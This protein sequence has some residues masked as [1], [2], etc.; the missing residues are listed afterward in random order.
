MLK[1]VGVLVFLSAQI[2]PGEQVFLVHFENSEA[3]G[4]QGIHYVGGG[5]EGLLSLKTIDSTRK[6][7][8]V[9]V[10]KVVPVLEAAYPRLVGKI[11][12]EKFDEDT[13]KLAKEGKVRV[14]GM[15]KNA[16]F[17]S[18]A[19]FG[20][21]MAAAGASEFGAISRIQVVHKG[22]VHLYDL[23]NKDHAGTKLEAGDFVYVP[24]KRAIG[25]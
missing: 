12:V 22:K 14:A 17:L 10:G 1:R 25:F 5:K 3:P 15:V 13:A 16:G 23:R 8:D 6:L 4:P 21:L 7:P 18:P 11:T 9:P 24:P 20:D 2:L 19:S